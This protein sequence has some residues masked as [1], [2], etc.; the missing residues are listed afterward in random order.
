MVKKRF[1]KITTM[2]LSPEAFKKVRKI[3]DEIQCSMAAWI[4]QAI[5][6]KLERIDSKMS[7]IL[8]KNNA[9]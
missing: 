2:A 5:D 9:E 1:T 4:R 6:E 3:S 8:T 7:I